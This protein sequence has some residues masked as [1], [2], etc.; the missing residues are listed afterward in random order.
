MKKKLI[1]IIAVLVTVFM[2]SCKKDIQ[3]QKPVITN[4]INKSAMSGFV[5]KGPFLNGTSIAIYELDG[6]YNL[7]G[8]NYI[9]QIIDNTGLFQIKNISLVSQY[10]LLKADGYYFNEVTGNNSSAP[11][12]LY[13][14]TDISNKTSVNINILTNLEK[15]RI[16]YLISN[17]LSFTVAKKQAELEVL[18][19]FS[20]L[21]PDITDSDSLNI[22]LDGDNNAI[23][24]AISIITQGYRTES[25]LSDLLA[26]IS[27]DI[28][29]DGILNSSTL[30]SSLIN[31]AK[32]FD[33]T[34]IRNNIEKRYTDLGMT[35]TI[36]NFEKYIKLFLDST[37][38]VFTNNIVY[39]EFSNYG[40]NI[41]F[42]NKTTF[43]SSSA[44]SMA[45]NL[46]FGTALKIIIKISDNNHIWGIQA[47]PNGPINWS[48]S[49]FNNS[50]TQTFTAINSGTNSDLIISF[51]PGVYTVEYYENNSTTPTRTKD[52][53]IN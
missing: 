47:A 41:L 3:E 46:P 36:P 48:M 7:T 6:T 9:T 33:L 26:N 17:G 24:L 21:K 51:S 39:P 49:T 2:I 27:T 23:L 18:K 16:E 19:V 31:D 29:T 42:G 35:V 38:Y 10:V 14:L 53:T 34:K 40:E 43:S 5:Q 50:M 25:G 13:D 28:R 30:G 37:S 8:K 20:I 45:A 11:I 15:S 32:L 4:G 22:S 12:T 1:F 44:L 52:I